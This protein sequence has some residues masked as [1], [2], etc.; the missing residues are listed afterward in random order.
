MSKIDERGFKWRLEWAK[1]SLQESNY[2][3]LSVRYDGGVQ[4]GYIL[5]AKR[6][7]LFQ[8]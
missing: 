6:H 7:Q 1:G 4:M 5:V 8:F 3:S 2:A